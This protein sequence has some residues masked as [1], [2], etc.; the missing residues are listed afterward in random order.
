MDT[1][2]QITLLNA[3]NR[4]YISM[5]QKFQNKMLNSYKILV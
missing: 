2:K 5:F 4:L 1:I 3:D